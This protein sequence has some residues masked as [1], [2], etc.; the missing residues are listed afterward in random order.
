[1][2][3]SEIIHKNRLVYSGALLCPVN[4]DESRWYTN[5]CLHCFLCLEEKKHKNQNL[6][7]R[8]ERERERGGG[9]GTGDSISLDTIK[10]KKPS[11][12]GSLP[13]SLFPSLQGYRVSPFKFLVYFSVTHKHTH[14][15]TQK[16]RN[17]L[18]P[19]NEQ[20]CLCVC[21]IWRPSQRLM[22]S[23]IWM[24]LKMVCECRASLFQ[25]AS[26]SNQCSSGTLDDV[27]V[28]WVGHLKLLQ[29]DNC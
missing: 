4:H 29:R 20:F 10:K 1:M 28:T 11:L 25:E 15:L 17:T 16:D 22:Q 27:R 5:D 21:K 14:T 23:W 13:P 26:G 2:D 7:K 6:Y 9:G 12:S 19:L 18:S 24:N 3:L 8:K